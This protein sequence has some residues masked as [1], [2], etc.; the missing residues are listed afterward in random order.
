[1]G[2]KAVANKFNPPFE[3]FEVE[4]II[5]SVCSFGIYPVTIAFKRVFGNMGKQK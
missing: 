4:D 5:A 2:A 3:G 1:M